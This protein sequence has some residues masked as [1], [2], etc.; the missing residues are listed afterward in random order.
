MIF[1]LIHFAR[2]VPRLAYATRRE[3]AERLGAA[4]A[5]NLLGAAFAHVLLVGTGLNFALI[6][7]D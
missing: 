7:R 4:L 2:L 6:L 1:P 5:S 3:R